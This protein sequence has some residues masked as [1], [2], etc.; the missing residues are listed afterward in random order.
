MSEPGTPSRKQEPVPSDDAAAL[1]MIERAA[2]RMR[3]SVSKRTL[4]KLMQREL[5]SQFDMSVGFVVD[6]VDEGAEQPGQEVTVGMVADRVGVDPSRASR[7]VAEAVRGGYVM[8]VASQADGRSSRLELT[9]AGR[10]VVEMTRRFRQDYF[11]H[12][13]ADWSEHDRAEFARLF[14]KFTESAETA[15]VATGADPDSDAGGFGSG[16]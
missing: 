2:V 4:G 14:A 11:D 5:G 3:R 15:D 7:L 1:A 16:P 13:M 12:R 10:E 6:V 9:D 8:R